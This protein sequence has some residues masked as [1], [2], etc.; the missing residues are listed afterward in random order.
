MHFLPLKHNMN[1]L[2]L[3]FHITITMVTL[4]IYVPVAIIVNQWGITVLWGSLKLV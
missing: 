2:E 4:Y 1:E 3:M